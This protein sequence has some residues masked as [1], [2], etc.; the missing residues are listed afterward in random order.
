LNKADLRAGFADIAPMMIA[1]APIAAIWGAYAASKG[2]SPLEA[3]LMSA[4]VYSGAGQAV[5]MDLWTVAPLPLLAFT[6]ATVALRHVLMSASLSRHM[7]SFSKWQASALLFWLTDEAWALMERRAMQRPISP[8]YFFGV[9]FPLWPTWFVFTFIGA[10]FGEWMGDTARFGLDFAFSA[11]FIAVVAGFWKGPKTGAIITVSSLVAVA[12]YLM[13][14]NTAW[15]I[16]AGGFA[17]MASAV[18]L[19]REAVE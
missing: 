13:I 15:Y 6:V 17:G 8:S 1:Y 9:A 12:F 16:I 4:G 7:A 18:A 2:L 19:H 10:R 3:L 11:M 14:P 5:A